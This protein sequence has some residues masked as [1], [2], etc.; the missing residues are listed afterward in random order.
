MSDHPTRFELPLEGSKL[1]Q[2][3]LDEIVRRVVEVAQPER[4]ILFG[5]AARGDMT[6]DSDVDLLVVKSGVTDQIRLAQEIHLSFWGLLVPIDVIVV[7]PE[8]IAKFANGV[9]TI[10]PSAMEEGKVIYGS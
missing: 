10:I 8:D 7:S 6:H 3:V 9:G 5:S 1:K 4:I 2:D